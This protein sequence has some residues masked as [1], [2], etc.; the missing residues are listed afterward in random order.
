VDRY[1]EVVL[2]VDV[3]FVDGIPFLVSVARGINLITAQFTAVRTA[4]NLAANV[5]NIL[6]VYVKGGL[7]VSTLLMDNEF[8]SLIILLPQLVIN[9]TAA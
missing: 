1:Q 8:E 4:N 2:A 7:K 5:K 9:T 3:M 6:Q